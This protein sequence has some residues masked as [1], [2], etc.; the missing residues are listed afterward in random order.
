[1]KLSYSLLLVATIGFT[2]CGNEDNKS[3]AAGSSV[4]NAG[5]EKLTAIEWETTTK[6]YGTIQEGQKLEVSFT[7]KNV[8]NENLVIKSV[9]PSC[10]CTAAEPP[11]KPIPPGGTGEIKASFDSKGRMG[12]NHKDLYVE[13]NTEGT[14]THR[15][16]F[17]VKVN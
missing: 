7:F 5:T 11:A 9:S 17:D 3:A 6:D 13:A 16:V 14:K 8:G 12:E 4:Q 15:L 1:M 2:A 10:G